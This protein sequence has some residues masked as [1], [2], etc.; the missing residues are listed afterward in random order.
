MK[1]DKY[2]IVKGPHKI[3]EADS[4]V[5]TLDGKADILF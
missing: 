4:R 3:F 2:I 1:G 5:D